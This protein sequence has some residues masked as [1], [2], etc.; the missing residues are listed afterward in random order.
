MPFGASYREQKY[1][2]QI[3]VWLGND[4]SWRE[5]VG[6][7]RCPVKYFGLCSIGNRKSSKARLCFHLTCALRR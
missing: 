4:M 7:L 5:V 6:G 3:G 2:A 1:R